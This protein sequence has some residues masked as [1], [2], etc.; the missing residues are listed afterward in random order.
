MRYSPEK[1]RSKRHLPF[2]RPFI[3]AVVTASPRSLAKLHLHIAFNRFVKA[4]VRPHDL[5]RADVRRQDYIRPR[6]SRPPGEELVAVLMAEL[7]HVQPHQ[8]AFIA[9]EDHA[10]E[11]Q[12]EIR[13]SLASGADEHHRR[14]LPRPRRAGH[15]QPPCTPPEGHGPARLSNA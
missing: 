2:G 8:L 15:S 13:L 10:R 7:R 4:V 1:G 11:L 5:V 9:I 3:W 14:L 12:R 6:L